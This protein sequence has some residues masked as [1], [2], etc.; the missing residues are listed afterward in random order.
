MINKI[1]YM[2]FRVKI[3]MSLSTPC[4]KM[5]QAIP[6]NFS[7]YKNTEQQSTLETLFL[8]GNSF[9]ETCKI[10]KHENKENLTG[11]ILDLISRI[12]SLG[13]PEPAL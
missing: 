10:L 8:A 13:E 12:K 3:F 11:V 1:V 7:Q 4:L 6:Y 5:Y 2:V 9:T